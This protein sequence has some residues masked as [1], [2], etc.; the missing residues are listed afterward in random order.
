[1]GVR[2]LNDIIFDRIYKVIEIDL[3]SNNLFDIISDIFNEYNIKSYRCAFEYG[4]GHK[5]L[6]VEWYDRHNNANICIEP[7]KKNGGK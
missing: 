4:N 5:Y 6:V 7:M 2:E 3:Y 1:M